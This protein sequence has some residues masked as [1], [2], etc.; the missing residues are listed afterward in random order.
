MVAAA[1]L[2]AGCGGSSA[3]DDSAEVSLTSSTTTTAPTT[4]TTEP[5]PAGFS[6]AF[7][8]DILIH[9]WVWEEAQRYAGGSGYDFAPMFSEIKPVL[10]SV[11]LAVCHLEVPIAPEGEE[12]Q[13]FPFY[14][15]PKELVVGIKEAGYDR[16]STASNHTID[17][18]IAGV[19]ATI[20]AFKANKLG[21]S[22][23][24]STPEDIEP[25]VFKV[26]GFKVTHLSYT[27]GYNGIEM[28][29]GEDWRSALI[30]ADRIIADAQKARDMGAQFVFVSMHWGSE[31]LHQVMSD[32]RRNAEKITASGL[33]DLIVGHHSHVLQPIEQINGVWTVFGLGNILS[34]H[35]TREFFPPESQ[36]G[37]VVVVDVQF[38]LNGKPIVGRPVV[39]PTW[40]DKDN[41]YVIRDV[42]AGLF[43][44]TTPSALRQ[45]LQISLDR[46]RKYVGD[47]IP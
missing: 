1:L 13:T 8:G 4:T 9:T 39:H 10:D 26:N 40:V 2:L 5:K 34:S 27:W 36:D 37:A 38:G 35:P 3:S 15:A 43:N 17:Q 30:N 47:F 33:V 21:Q 14:A 32:Q 25:K 41:G 11:D 23:M 18:G 46:S 12:P 42:G 7:S 31:P 22:G 28:P 16:C 24:A 29:N 6:L 44:A 45:N 19:E 20:A